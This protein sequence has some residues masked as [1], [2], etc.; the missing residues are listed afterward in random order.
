M[1][2]FAADVF[3]LANQLPYVASIAV[4]TLFCARF[5]TSPFSHR[6][7]PLAQTCRFDSL[8]INAE[9]LHHEQLLCIVCRFDIQFPTMC[10]RRPRRKRKVTAKHSQVSHAERALSKLLDEVTRAEN[11][12]LR[13]ELARRG[14]RLRG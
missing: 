4:P 7:G 10:G 9:S 1:S 2:Y 14:G 8:Q 11:Q 3:A 6:F 5:R 12:R 13:E